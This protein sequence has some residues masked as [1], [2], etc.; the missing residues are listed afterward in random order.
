MVDDDDDGDNDDKHSK[1]RNGDNDGGE[2]I[3][4]LFCVFYTWSG[5]VKT[6][7]EN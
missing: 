1:R 3:K 5:S 7:H 4:I 6:S 2:E